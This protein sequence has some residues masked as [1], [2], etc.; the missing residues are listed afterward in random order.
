M[1]LFKLLGQGLLIV[2]YAAVELFLG[3]IHIL[4]LDV[5]VLTCRKAVVLLL[6]FILCHS[7]REIVYGFLFIEGVDNQVYLFWQQT[8][9]LQVVFLVV[10]T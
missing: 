10:L 7:Y 8:V 4:N 3:Y 9:L 2:G 1:A 5:E 6:D